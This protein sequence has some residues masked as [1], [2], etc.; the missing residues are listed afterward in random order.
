MYCCGLN[1][2]IWSRKVYFRIIIEEKI[3]QYKIQNNA[4]VFRTKKVNLIFFFFVTRKE[5][6][7]QCDI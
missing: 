1:C 6:M 5:V 2:G 4:F 3:L 7:E